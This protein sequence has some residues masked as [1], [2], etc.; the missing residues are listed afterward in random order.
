MYLTLSP[1]QT[2]S[3]IS[4]AWSEQWSISDRRWFHYHHEHSGKIL[5]FPDNFVQCR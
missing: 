2:M 5:Q 4:T 1:E 3:R